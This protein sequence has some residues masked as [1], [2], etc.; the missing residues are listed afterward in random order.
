[1]RAR[2]S[3]TSLLLASAGTAL[4]AAAG[5]GGSGSTSAGDT[6]SAAKRGGTIRINLASDTDYTDPALAYYSVSWQF[7]YATGLKLLNYPDRP[8]PEGSRLQPEASAGMPAVSSDGKTYTFTIKQGFR[9]SPPSQE[10][11]T[12]ESFKRALERVLSPSMQSPGAPFVMDIAGAAAFRDGTARSLA[13]VVVKGD[14]LTISLVDV[15]PDFLARLAMP[16]FSAVPASTPANPAGERQIPSAGPYYIEKWVPKR[17]LVLARNP[18]YGGDRSALADRF[19]Y[20][21]GVNPAQGL[22]QIEKGEAD[23]AADGLPAPAHAELGA[24]YG[25]GSPA[26]RKGRQQYFVNPTLAFRYLALNTS[27]PLFSDV[28][29]RQAVNFSL[30]R[31]ALIRQRGAYAGRATDQY[32]PY[33]LDGFTDAG[34]YPLAHPDVERARQLA[35]SGKRR[36]AV[37]YTCSEAPC[38]QTAQ[39]IQ[40]NLKAIGIDVT[41]RQFERAIQYQRQGIRG[42]PFDIAYDGWQADYA[43]PYDFINV[44][45]DGTRIRKA[46]NVN[47]S[48]FDDPSFTEKMHAAAR[49]AGDRRLQAYGMLDIELA[50]DAA[51]LAAWVNDNDRDFFSARIGCQVYSPVYAMDIAALCVRR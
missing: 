26:A 23:Y 2:R 10:R 45:L 24:K 49:L 8:A 28:R 30:D 21:V 50:R 9:F 32:L 33:S 46:N 39:I 41:I 6:T 47:F 38:P 1:M 22:L 3:I 20:T 43:D 48:Y 17:E 51:P 4:L 40:A 36:R 29:L 5:C 27:R 11:V 35:G 25:P 12:A 19:V 42:E 16:F 15:A 13:G 34:I 14:T 7:E 18:H 31:A 37:L 44:L